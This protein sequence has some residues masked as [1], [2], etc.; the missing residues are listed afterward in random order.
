MPASVSVVDHQMPGRTTSF[1][2]RALLGIFG[3]F[4]S[5]GTGK[6]ESPV[7]P[8]LKTNPLYWRVHVNIQV[9][10]AINLNTC[11]CAC[12]CDMNPDKDLDIDMDM[13]LIMNINMNMSMNKKIM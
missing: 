12:A 10:M 6:P 11:P 4:F 13:K 3:F 5:S 1:P 8:Q 9:S 7:L 2:P